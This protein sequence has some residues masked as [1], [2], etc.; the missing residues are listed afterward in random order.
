MAVKVENWNEDMDVVICL[1]KLQKTGVL[2]SAVALRRPL[3][4][5]TAFLRFLETLL[6]HR[7]EMTHPC[8]ENNR[9]KAL[10]AGQNRCKGRLGFLRSSAQYERLRQA[11]PL[12]QRVKKTPIGNWKR[13]SSCPFGYGPGYKN[14]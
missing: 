1:L 2:E 13:S 14:L 9:D 6:D 5:T 10:Q 8:I 11:C 4:I 7:R 3:E 12:L